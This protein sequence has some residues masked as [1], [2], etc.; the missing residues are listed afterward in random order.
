MYHHM[1]K[2]RSAS[3]SRGSL[4][5]FSSGMVGFTLLELLIGMAL[6]LIL[7]A[8]VFTLFG[9][10]VLVSQSAANITDMNQNLRGASDLIARS[11]TVAGAGIPVGGITM[12]SGSGSSSVTWP[13][14]TNVS[15]CNVF[16]ANAGVL[17][18]ITPGYQC[19]P[20]IISGVNQQTT[21]KITIIAVDPPFQ[22]SPLTTPNTYQVPL[23]FQTGGSTYPVGIAPYPNGCAASPL[24]PLPSPCTGWQVAVTG[25]SGFNLSSGQYQ[26]NVK[27]LIMFNNSY[28]STLGMVTAVDT[29][30]NLITF[31]NTDPLGLNQP[32]ATTGSPASLANSD[33][34]WPPTVGYKIDM[35]TFYL[36]NPGGSQQ[37]QLMQQYNLATAVP[38]A[39][40]INVLQFLYDLS[41][42]TTGCTA[43]PW[44][45]NEP[46]SSACS[47]SVSD[48]P[49]MIAKVRMTISGATQPLTGSNNRIF[50]DTLHVSVTIRDLAFRNKY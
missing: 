5:A 2:R 25:P 31:V 44:T 24:P 19:G 43:L 28:G 17:S 37:P 50:V 30:N 4:T 15:G 9:K 40:G 7:L 35:N 11:L 46:T 29:T 18:A 26:I 36:N 42:G 3:A 10:L 33:G 38:V 23:S 21:D 22:G 12:P 16:P 6:T 32:S 13:G 39:L 14:P 41:D 34:S 47:G 27:D 1:F 49:N 48:S 45:S 20:T 8:A